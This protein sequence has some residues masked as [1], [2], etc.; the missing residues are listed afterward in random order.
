MEEIHVYYTTG[1]FNKKTMQLTYQSY[2][3][4]KLKLNLLSVEN[5][6]MLDSKWY[7]FLALKQVNENHDFFFVKECVFPM[8]YQYKR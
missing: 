8:Q 3:A 5:I 6:Y 7:V 1:M 4:E 2:L